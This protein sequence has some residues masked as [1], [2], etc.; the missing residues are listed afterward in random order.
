MARCSKCDYKYATQQKCPNCGE[1]DPISLSEEFGSAL[2]KLFWFSI[3][4][5]ICYTIWPAEVSKVLRAFRNIIY[6]IPR[7]FSGVE[8]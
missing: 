6:A 3:L 7:L 2:Q 1:T 5:F 8:T 4:V